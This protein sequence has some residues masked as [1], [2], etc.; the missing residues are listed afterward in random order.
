MISKIFAVGFDCKVEPKQR[1]TCVLF[2][3]HIL[4]NF[5]KE[6]HKRSR[7]QQ[8]QPWLH[9][10]LMHMLGFYG[11]QPNLGHPDD[12]FG[13]PTTLSVALFGPLAALF[14]PPTALSG[15]EGV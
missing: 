1:K 4:S 6:F 13:P 5:E 10:D 7:K 14:G 9:R 8:P 12:L 15:P 3:S 2:K 11:F